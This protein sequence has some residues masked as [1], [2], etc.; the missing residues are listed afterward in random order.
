MD[1]ASKSNTQ[2]VDF[3]GKGKTTFLF[4]WAE[5]VQ[6]AV[7]QSVIHCGVAMSQRTNFYYYSEWMLSHYRYGLLMIGLIL[8]SFIQNQ[9]I[10]SVLCLIFAAELCLR[11]AVMRYKRQTNPYKT[12]LN[13][14][15]DIL[16]LAFDLI[17]LLSLL[18]SAFDVQF[19]LGDEGAAARFLRAFYL[20]RALRLF[21]YIDMQSMMFSPG[22]GMFISLIVMLSF[23][24]KGHLLWAIIIYF[25]VEIMIRFVLLRNMSFSSRRDRLGEWFFWWIDV[26]ATIVMVPGLTSIPYG[27]ALRALRLVRLLRP[28]LVILRNL[29]KVFQEGDYTQEIILVILLLAMLSI[30][31]G[32]IGHFSMDGFDFNQDALISPTDH[33]LFVEIWFT[34][35]TLMAAGNLVTDPLGDDNLALF[36]VISVVLGMFILAFFIGIG[37]SIIS[38][39]MA[40][41]RNEKLMM[42][43]HMV[44]I[45]WNSASPFIIEKLKL[46]SDHNF[47]RLKLV[48]LC[49]HDKR[50]DELENWVTF[51]WGDTEDTESMQR[52]NLGSA[53][54]AIVC[55]NESLSTSEEL[56]QNLFSLMAIRQANP[57]IPV[58]YTV[59]G[60][61]QP[62]LTSYRHM[63]QIG[64][65]KV[66]YYNKPTVLMSEPDMRA[67]LIRNVLVYQDFD[68]VLS[69]LMVP[70]R[71]DESAM[72]VVEWQ[73]RIACHSDEWCFVDTD[74][75]VPAHE[76]M[77]RCF[78]QGVILIAVA[79]EALQVH[80]L[81]A[82]HKDIQVT[83]LL[84]LAI[85]NPTLYGEFYYCMGAN[86]PPA[87]GQAVVKLGSLPDQHNNSH[88]K[89][90]V[91]GWVGTLPLMLKRLLDS[92]QHIEVTILDDLSPEEH[93]DTK[94]YVQRRINEMPGAQARV[95]IRILRWDFSNMEALRE[96][97][98]VADKVIVSRPAHIHRKPHAM[99][100]SVLSHTFSLAEEEDNQPQL[101]AIV[102][103]RKQARMLQHELDRFPLS[104]DVNVVVPTEFYGTYA[105]HTSFLMYHA[106][107]ADVYNMHR[108]LRYLLDSLMSDSVTGQSVPLTLSVIPMPAVD[109]IDAA[110]LYASLLTRGIFWLG[111]RIDP[112]I[113]GL[114]LRSNPVMRMFPRRHDFQCLRQREI[115]IN[116]LG[117]PETRHVWA[118]QQQHIVELIVIRLR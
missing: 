21:R 65:D 45:G 102:D 100:A 66:D 98:G 105:A 80:P 37:S 30:T 84:G 86:R 11:V 8:L 67:N 10:A 28:W 62:R 61:V 7:F 35:R 26:I 31:G 93:T 110:D 78:E 70:E 43:N 38:G 88:V 34:F 42:A 75:C 96:H 64:W 109:D 55:T 101:Y 58:S 39:L 46:L 19:L 60:M 36:S 32:V 118:H 1:G 90:L 48:F 5:K 74:H 103:T 77:R 25:A 4:L 16:F 59:M 115:M 99:V 9:V 52:V 57:E 33:N 50:P 73:G 95:S 112:A 40:K 83:S 87:S 114:R 47:S 107:S 108:S 106:T 49:E 18:V 72:Q 3:A 97:V 41:L 6:D 92:Y 111:F 81:N 104:M 14:K 85:D 63:L 51:R 68:Q 71:E 13:L 27:N 53:R 113:A 2:G 15:L 23:F 54:Q 12:S 44:M 117:H 76:I 17:A 89:L 91:V 79:D 29:V 94:A 22:Y 82:L 20:L 56:S 24:V 69:R 116:P